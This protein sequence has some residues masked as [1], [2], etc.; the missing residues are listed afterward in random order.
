MVLGDYL[1]VIAGI[2]HTK[3]GD[4][5]KGVMGLAERTSD[6]LF[7]P[8]GVYSLWARGTP[9]KKDHGKLPATNSY[10]VHPFYMVKAS[11]DSWF[12]VYTNLANAQDWWVKND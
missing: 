9:I 1:N 2:A 8:N 10:G 3:A 6:D 4:S 11:D 12:G 7:L 5:F